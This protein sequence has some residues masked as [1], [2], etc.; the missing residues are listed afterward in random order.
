VQ[1]LELLAMRATEHVLPLGRI[2]SVFVAR[3]CSRDAPHDVAHEALPP[4][5][6]IELAHRALSP[7][8]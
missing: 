3:T 7:F 4:G 6:R 1:I 5:T 8:A 2:G